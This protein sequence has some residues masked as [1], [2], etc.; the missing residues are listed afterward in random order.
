M[1]ATL[2]ELAERAWTAYQDS[3]PLTVTP[4]EWNLLT[5]VEWRDPDGREDLLRQ[6]KPPELRM[7]VPRDLKVVV[8]R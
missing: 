6:T 4:E 2:P 7:P 3:Q 1:T 8:S 5:E